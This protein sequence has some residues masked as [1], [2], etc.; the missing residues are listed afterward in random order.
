MTKG[1]ENKG[2]RMEVMKG[3]LLKE[4]KQKK[5]K[6]KKRK[7]SKEKRTREHGA[8]PSKK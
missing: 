3:C 7:L 1:K 4:K 6:R 8:S 2:S 5:R